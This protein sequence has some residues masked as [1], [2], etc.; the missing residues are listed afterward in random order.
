MRKWISTGLFPAA[1]GVPWQLKPLRYCWKWI[2]KELATPDTSSRFQWWN[3]C[4]FLGKSP[5]EFSR[6]GFYMILLF[7]NQYRRSCKVSQNGTTGQI[8]SAFLSGQVLQ[9]LRVL[10]LNRFGFHHWR[11]PVAP[12]FRIQWYPVASSGIPS[13]PQLPNHII[14]LLWNLINACL[15]TI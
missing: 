1:A 15:R 6:L 8:N 10:R 2:V 4:G 11:V 5:C 9:V 14:E 7:S 13:I 3:R 12:L